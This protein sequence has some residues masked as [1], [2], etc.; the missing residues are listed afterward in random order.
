[1]SIAANALSPALTTSIASFPDSWKE[2][3]QNHSILLQYFISNSQQYSGLENHSSW[4]YLSSNFPSEVRWGLRVYFN[5]LHITLLASFTNSNVMEKY[6]CKPLSSGIMQSHTAI[7]QLVLTIAALKWG[8][9]S[10]YWAW[11]QAR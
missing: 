5:F 6:I 4:M 2:S 7:L 1:M 10:I 11:K 3:H 9:Y 8:S